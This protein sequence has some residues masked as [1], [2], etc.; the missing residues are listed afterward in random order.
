MMPLLA[1]RLKPMTIAPGLHQRIPAPVGWVWRM[2][3]DPLRFL[4]EVRERYGDVVRLHTGP[5]RFHLVAHPDHVRHVLL[6]H[7]KNYPRSWL[8]NRTKLAAGTG[9]VTTEGAAWRR[10]RRMSQ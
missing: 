8:Y 1:S 10:L 7:Q 3:R 9:L 6:D 4:V 5:W 2:Q